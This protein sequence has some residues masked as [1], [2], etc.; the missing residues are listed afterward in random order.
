MLLSFLLALT[1]FAQP[2]QVPGG[3]IEGVTLERGTKRPLSDV[4]VYILPHK[5]KATTDAQ[6]RFVFEGV[7]MGEYE[8]VV[9]LAN[10]KNYSR[11]DV[12]DL[13][14]VSVPK[15]ILLERANYQVFE[16]TVRDRANK[17]DD[18]TRSM[19][20]EQF[21]NV[22]GANGDPVKAVQNLPGVA[23]VQGFSSQVIIQGSAPEDTSYLLDD[24]DVPLIFHFGGLTSVITPE[25]VEQVD[26]LSGGYGPEYGRAMGGLIGLKTRNPAT[27]RMKG[28]AFVDIT[29]S[30]GMVEGP[31]DE[32]SSYLVAARYSYLGLVL[33]EALKDEPAFNLTVAPSFGDL[34]GIYKKK[35]SNGDEFKFLSIVSHDELKFVLNEPLRED[36]GLRGEFSNT[37]DFYRL[38]PQW[39]R[40]LSAS[41]AW[42]ASLGFGE[43]KIKLNAGDNFLDIESMVVTQRTEWEKKFRPTWTSYLGLDTRL[44]RSDVAFK[45]PAVGRGGGV[46]DPFSSG[47]TVERSISQD[48]ILI[49]PYWR[50][51]IKADD[52]RWTLMPS[53]RVDYFNLT[54]EILPQPRFAVRYDQN[55]SLFYKA[56]AGL[57]YQ[58]PQPQETSP[59][60]GNPDVESPRAW[61]LTAGLDKD[62]REGATNGFSLQT[63]LFYRKFEKL[64]VASEATVVRNGVQEF[65]RFNNDG[66]GHAYGAEF[67]VRFEKRPWS[68]WLSYTLSRSYRKE[69]GQ[70]EYLFEYDQTHNI[71]LVGAY[72]AKNN[73]RYSSRL[74]YVT[75][76]PVTPVVGAT[77]DADN[78]VYV[79]KRGPYFSERNSPFV[80]LD[81]RIDKTWVYDTWLLNAYLDIQNA[82][83]QQNSE[84]IRYSYNYAEK[85]DVAGL[86]VLPTFGIRGEF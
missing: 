70:G 11:K 38:I 64:V 77:F 63:N 58:P 76:N 62:F 80:Q 1:T 21:L 39:E 59:G 78:D 12:L 60:F 51:R 79:P 75:G 17:R 3:R 36:P 68:G 48:E 57:Y 54:E 32:T 13:S 2:V 45:L 46:D 35:L 41:E 28:F 34:A 66:Q 49:G 40:R 26:Y 65:E 73:W 5:L 24:H 55:S 33:G 81:V 67:L 18:S 61:H 71:N 83:N 53:L 82:T 14:K 15:K 44:S 31:I 30:G 19:K 56:A 16:I 52:S 37:T 84:G 6:G 50:N 74:R 10:Y 8:F 86:P 9:N 25:A 23:R 27:D 47:E 85:R 7:P 20:A 69:P 72:E 43:D 4:N 42:R 22:P 29:K